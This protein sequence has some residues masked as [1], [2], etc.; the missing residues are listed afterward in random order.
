MKTKSLLINIFI[1]ILCLPITFCSQNTK[2][3]LKDKFGKNQTTILNVEH[4]SNEELFRDGNYAMFIHWGMYSMLANRYQGETYY[5]IGEWMMHPAMAGIPVEEY[6]DL[7]KNFNPVNFNAKEIVQLAKDAGMKY[8][9][10]TSKHHDGF[11]MFDSK[12]SD[13]NI[14]D[15][16][17]FDRDPMKELAQECKKA[18]LGFGFYYSQNQDWTAPGGNR[19]PETDAQG[20]PKTFDNYF[21]EKCLPQVK[22]ITTQYGDIVLIWFDTPGGIQKKYVEGLIEVVRKNQPDALISGRVGHNMGD[23]KTLGDMEIPIK[24]MEGMWETVDVTNDSWGYAWYDENWK[25]PVEILRRLISTVARGGTYMLN[26]GPKGDGSIPVD[27]A[28]SLRSAGDWIKRY[29]QVVYGAG[30]SP[31]QHRLPWGDVTVRKNRL[32]LSIYK[33]PLSGEIFLPGLKTPVSSAVLLSGEKEKPLEYTKEKGW[34]RFDLPHQRPEEMISVIQVDL[35]AEPEADTVH[36]IGPNYSIPISVNFA[37][38]QGCK[39]EKKRWMEKFGEWKHE[40]QAIKW[41]ENGK[42]T[43]EV[44]VYT[45]GQY[46]IE[47]E[48]TG[49]GKVVWKVETDEN[50]MIQNQQHATDRFHKSPIGWLEFKT[51]GRHKVSVSM[52]EGKKTTGLSGIVFNPVHFE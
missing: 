1:V 26:I 47:L 24:N 17:P 6:K 45:P 16:T 38:N 36:G 10:I 20:N 31:W 34:I 14:V 23:Y 29:P 4:A 13:F 48:H 7:A 19:G 44:D 43:W 28:R 3:T 9:I 46:K 37:E 21:Y 5:G 11:A 12:A 40:M 52:V 32:Y 30:P 51:P 2:K 49:S 41:E 22:E 18:G 42:V 25:S 50:E 33:W 8:I 27:P 15:A 35:S 39:I